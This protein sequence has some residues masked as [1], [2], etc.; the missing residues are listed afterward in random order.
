MIE[1]ELWA[2]STNPDPECVSII[3]RMSFYLLNTDTTHSSPQ[4][5]RHIGYPLVPAQQPLLTSEDF[6]FLFVNCGEQPSGLLCQPG[7]AG[8]YSPLMSG[9]PA[10]Q[11]GPPFKS[12]L[13]WILSLSPGELSGVLLS[14]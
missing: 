13:P 12:P 8:R 2:E 10:L 14:L 1:D 3:K 9:S 7:A 5:L 6:S 4:D 11:R